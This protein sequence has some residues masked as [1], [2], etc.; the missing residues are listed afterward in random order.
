MAVFGE[1]AK[2]NSANRVITRGSSVAIL[3]IVSSSRGLD[4]QELIAHLAPSL[5]QFRYFVS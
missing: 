2:Q 3:F 5:L 4:R 1:R